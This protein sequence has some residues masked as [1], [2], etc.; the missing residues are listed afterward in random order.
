[1]NKLTQTFLATIML[2][3]SFIISA[4]AEWR[5]EIGIFRVGVVTKQDIAR[6]IEHYQPFKKA[7]SRAL[8]IDVEIFPVKSETSLI[9]ALAADRIEYAILSASG[10]ALSWALCECVEPLVTART[11]DSGDAYHTVVI[12]PVTGISGVDEL[13]NAK[14][15]V[16]TEH[17]ISGHPFAKFLLSA[18]ENVRVDAPQSP[19]VSHE[20]G[21]ETLK[22]FQ[23]GELDALIGWSSMNGDPTNGYS[24]G[25]L[26]QLARLNDDDAKPYRI[27]WNSPPL[28]YRPHAI[29]K[30]L[31]G[32]AKTI[33][34]TT[35][36]AL[37]DRSPVA[38]DVIEPHYGGGFIV[39]RHSLFEPLV[40]FVQSLYKPKPQQI[41][42]SNETSNET[43]G[44][45]KE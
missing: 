37:Y 25:T 5:Q 18:E 28:P 17:S 35:M 4:F 33:L 9:Q 44:S 27:I 34:R 45:V 26:K 3:S 16:L 22:A 20:Q 39:S 30:N 21:V 32:E 31:N 36:E 15:G 6:T 42:P 43:I 38:Y 19:F 24:A 23:N 12:A 29:A 8:E 40:E 2:T 41:T 1:M 11:S 13:E 7:L 14:I 10:Y